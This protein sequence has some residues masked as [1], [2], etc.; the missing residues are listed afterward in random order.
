MR[1]EFFGVAVLLYTPKKKVM[2][3]WKKDDLPD[4]KKVVFWFKSGYSSRVHGIE[5]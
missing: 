2:E 5:M 3:V 4:F 1:L